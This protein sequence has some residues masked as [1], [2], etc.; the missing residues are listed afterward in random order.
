MSRTISGYGSLL[1][2]RWADHARQLGYD[3]VMAMTVPPDTKPAYAAT[4]RFYERH[5]FSI[6]KR[7]DELWESGALEMVKDL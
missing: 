1:I 7:Y 6:A 5:G 3:R 4:V 2:D